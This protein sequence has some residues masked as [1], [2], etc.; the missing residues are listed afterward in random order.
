[1]AAKLISLP[2]SLK[3]Y[4]KKKEIISMELVFFSKIRNGGKK[5]KIFQ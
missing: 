3:C 5:L 1:M 2:K 4:L